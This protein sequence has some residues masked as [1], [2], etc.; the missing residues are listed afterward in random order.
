MIPKRPLHSSVETS[1]EHQLRLIINQSVRDS[2]QILVE[3]G[4]KTVCDRS[5]SIGGTIWVAGGTSC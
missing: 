2:E 5:G 1:V 4:N 3:T